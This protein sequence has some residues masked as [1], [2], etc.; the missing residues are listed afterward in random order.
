MRKTVFLTIFYVILW[1]SAV[2]AATP[3]LFF[4]DI[5]DGPRIG[6]EESS[7]RGVAVTIWGNNFGSTRGSNYVTVGGIQLTNDSDYAEWGVT[8]GNARDLERIT[9]Y[10]NNNCNSGA[11][12]IIVTVNGATSNELDFYVH[13]AGNIYYVDATNG[14]DSYNGLYASYRGFVSGP[15]KTLVYARQHISSGDIVYIR[16][17]IYTAGDSYNSILFLPPSIN[18]SS[19]NYT[20]F[21]GYPGELPILD[22]RINSDGGVIRNCYDYEGNTGYTT[23]AKIKIYPRGI[24]LRFNK[25]TVGNYRVVAIEVDGLNKTLPVSSTWGGAIDFHDMSNLKVYGCHIFYWGKDKYDHAMY[26]GNDEN[27]WNCFNI[28]IGWNEI[29]DLGLESSG[30]YIHPKDSDPSNGYADE[31]NIHDNFCYNLSHAGIHIA[32]RIK[33]ISIWNNI[34]YNCGSAFRR[35]VIRFNAFNVVSSDIKFYNN[36][37]YSKANAALIIF[38]NQSNVTMKNNIIYSLSG[39]PYY[40]DYG[41][42]GTRSS[43]YDLWY[44]RGAPPRWAMHALNSNPKFFNPANYDFRLQS[45]SP[46]KDTGTSAVNTIVTRDFDGTPRPQGTGYDIG[47]HENS[48]I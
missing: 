10:L 24:A 41:Y 7:T 48:A 2:S 14:S 32:S 45:K 5:T 13:T 43:D 39:T 3:I 18:G 12:K 21:I 19:N 23:L 33:N 38:E 17:G 25:S 30:I 42:S 27:G 40:S 29:N 20:A 34:F 4:S 15:W 35:A 37:L 8:S 16:K 46:A 26:F 9:F 6:W 28:N 47:A 36:I 31:I 11:V 22:G 44:G 1:T